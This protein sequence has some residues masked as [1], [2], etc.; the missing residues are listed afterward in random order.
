V[1]VSN[2]DNFLTML[3]ELMYP[4]DDMSRARPPIKGLVRHTRWLRENLKIVQRNLPKFEGDFRIQL[5]KYV[6]RIFPFG[7]ELPIELEN[8]KLQGS[9]C[10]DRRKE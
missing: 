3:R 5:G 2:P 8:G 1:F 10:G 7:K 9:P 6:E 4:R